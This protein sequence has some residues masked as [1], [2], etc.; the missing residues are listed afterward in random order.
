M[1]IVTMFEDLGF[2]V[3]SNTLESF[4]HWNSIDGK[5]SL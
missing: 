5:R 4:G 2:I 1:L 3:A